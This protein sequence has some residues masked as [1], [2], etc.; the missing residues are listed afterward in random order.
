[1][2]QLTAEEVAAFRFQ[3]GATTAMEQG[4]LRS[5]I[6][7]SNAGS[8]R[9]GRRYLPHAFSK[10]GVSMPFGVLHSQRAIDVNIEVMRTFVQLRSMLAS[11]VELSAKLSPREEVR[12]SVQGGVRRHPLRP[13]HGGRTDVM[14]G[15]SLV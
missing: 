9:G 14:R 2:F 4:S 6:G 8:A 12:P 1:M 15:G 3:S 11:N 7:I 5:Q 13:S 10:Q